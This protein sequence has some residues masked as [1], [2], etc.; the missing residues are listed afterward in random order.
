MFFF[1]FFFG[2]FVLKFGL[3][4]SLDDGS[5][6][7]L[8]VMFLEKVKRKVDDIWRVLIIVIYFLVGLNFFCL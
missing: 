4:I 5:I 3:R 1:M 2:C 8:K 6:S 7:N